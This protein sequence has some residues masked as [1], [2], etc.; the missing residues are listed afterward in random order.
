MKDGYSGEFV[1]H[2][3][4]ITWMADSSEQ[5]G[6]PTLVGLLG[7]HLAVT[8]GKLPE[9]DLKA[10]ILDQI[11]TIFGSWALE[12]TGILL[13][14]WQTQ[15]FEQGATVCFPG[16]GTMQEFQT[17]RASHGPIHFAGTETSIR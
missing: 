6:C 8:F 9:E 1:S 17:I 2:S 5:N 13:K 7:G 10:A 14:I 4:P 3:G 15:P 12:P 11:T 16:I